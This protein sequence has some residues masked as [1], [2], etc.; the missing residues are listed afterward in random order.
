VNYSQKVKIVLELLEECRKYGLEGTDF[1]ASLSMPQVVAA[2]NGIG[3][4][5]FP[6]PLRKALDKL[7]PRLRCIALPHD[8]RFSYGDGTREDFEKANK[9]LKRNG[10]KVADVLYGKFN[11]M[12]YYMRYKT[13]AYAAL[14]QSLGWEVYLKACGKTESNSN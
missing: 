8:C 2:Y 14:C 12:R 7:N 3:P 5:S 4:E 10:R 6:K 13:K 9:E 1:V 11:P